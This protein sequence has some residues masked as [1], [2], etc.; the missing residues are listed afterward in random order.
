MKKAKEQEKN[1]LIRNND[2]CTICHLFLDKTK[3][4]VRNTHF[5]K[6]NEKLSEAFYHT[7][8]FKEKILG[9][10]ELNKIKKQAF[11]IM[12]FAKE[13]MGMD[14]VVDLN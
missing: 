3:D 14:E 2:V 11:G 4:F 12:K 10:G 9:V 6:E 1:P 5:K 7:Q 13:K 8:C